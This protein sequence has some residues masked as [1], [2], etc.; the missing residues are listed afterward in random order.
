MY[1]WE[2]LFSGIIKK[3]ISKI[4]HFKSFLRQPSY[5]F[6]EEIWNLEIIKQRFYNAVKLFRSYTL[7]VLCTLLHFIYE[8][9]QDG[10]LVDVHDPSGSI[11]FAFGQ[12]KLH[13]KFQLCLTQFFLGYFFGILPRGAY[14]PYQWNPS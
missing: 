14:W 11:F 5:K 7:D 9:E 1:H 4:Y 8:D 10:S 12:R 3:V 2:L 13:S 6:D